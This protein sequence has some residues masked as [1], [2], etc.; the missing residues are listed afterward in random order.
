MAARAWSSENLLQ[1]AS[2]SAI[3]E[4]LLSDF[5]IRRS[6]RVKNIKNPFKTKLHIKII[7]HQISK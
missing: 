5:K 4:P 2:K 7:L 6:M 1:I 3:R